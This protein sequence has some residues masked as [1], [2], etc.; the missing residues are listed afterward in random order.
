MNSKEKTAPV[1]ESQ[2]SPKSPIPV[3]PKR[4]KRPIGPKLHRTVGPDARLGRVG[5][6]GSAKVV[7]NPDCAFLVAE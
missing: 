1:V 7:S 6:W 2:K 4:P 5:P 3:R